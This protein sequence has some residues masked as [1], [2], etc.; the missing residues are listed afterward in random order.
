MTFFQLQN[1]FKTE[2]D[3]I[4]F[5]IKI[6]YPHGV[7]CPHCKTSHQ[8]S[9]R[10]DRPKNYNC[11]ICHN[12]FSV[13]KNTIFE[14][15][16]VELRKWFYAINACLNSKKGI[17]ACQLQREIGVTYKTAWRM[18]YKIRSAMGK[19][20]LK[21]SFDSIVEVD[22]TYIGGKPR[23]SN[24]NSETKRRYYKKGRGTRKTP[25]IG[26]RER[27]TGRVYAKVAF[28]DYNSR[29]LTGRQLLSVIENVTTENSTVISDD[30]KSY[31][32]LNHPDKNLKN[33]KHLTVNHSV[34]QYSAGDGIHTN[35][36]EG[37]WSIVK[38]SVYGTYHHISVRY[39]QSYINE[40][41]F[42]QNNKNED[43]FEKLLRLGIA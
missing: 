7:V 37:F 29:R 13:F 34:G 16:S 26:V 3:A 35:G 1:N 32:I 31:S 9:Q 20:N 33:Y 10:S 17:S 8:I 39:M 6:R 4:T 22:E 40:C 12:T 11:S 30:Y 14:K 38:R 42:K 24:F 19:E 41:C 18:L 27:Q 21:D 15:S 43:A 23:K 2:L 5:F 28:P 36:I 25:V